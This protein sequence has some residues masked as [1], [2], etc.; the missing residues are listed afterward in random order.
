MRLHIGHHFYGAGNV[1]DDLM[2]A[3]FLA[4]VAQSGLEVKLTCSVP[5]ELAPLK[6]RY[7]QVEWL[8]YTR[9]IRQA[10][11]RDCDA[12]IGVGDTPFQVSVGS[13][14]YDHLIGEIATC[15]QHGRRM[16]YVGIGVD[17]ETAL[18]APAAR[19]IIAAATHIW[20]R[21]DWSA[22]LLGN[23]YDRQ[24]LTAGADLAHAYLADVKWPAPETGVLGLV[25]NFEDAKQ[26]Q[27]A[28]IAQLID[29]ARSKQTVRWLVQEVRDLEGSERQ[30]LSMI[31]AASRP[32]DIRLPDYENAPTA[33]AL[34]QSWGVPEA[35]VTSRYHGGVI[36][37][38]AGAR[39]VLIERAG[40]V[41]ALANQLRTARVPDFTDAARILSALPTAVPVPRQRLTALAATA[42]ANVADLITRVADDL[43]ARC[44]S[45]Q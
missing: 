24:T 31:D 12:W 20:T 41:A 33:A 6:L 30:L 17:D 23:V 43:S 19:T 11:I 3:G 22:Q 4:G 45:L 15:Q 9:E 2:L 27:P 28:A 26:F 29:C 5:F 39:P 42:R 32:T 16:Y 35:V 14:F 37:A 34:V 10:A 8:H 1:G 25:L 44:A 18:R 13:W 40:K 21:D 7:P 38:W 36:A